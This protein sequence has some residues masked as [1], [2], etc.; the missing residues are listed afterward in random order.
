MKLLAFPQLPFLLSYAESATGKAP[1]TQ[2]P[3]AGSPTR[4]N[5]HFFPLSRHVLWPYSYEWDAALSLVAT[6][7]AK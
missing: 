4:W 1:T 5:D 7:T 3:T 6:K 2:L